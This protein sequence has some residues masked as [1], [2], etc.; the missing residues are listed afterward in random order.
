MGLG[1]LA[2]AAEIAWNQGINLYGVLDNRLYHGFEYTAK[3]MSG[4]EVP[5]KQYI[6]WYGKSVFGNTISTGQRTKYARHGNG[7]IGIIITEKGWECPIHVKSLKKDDRK[8]T[9]ISHSYHGLPSHALKNN[10]DGSRESPHRGYINTNLLK[11]RS[12]V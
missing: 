5:Y 1:F 6:T 11:A 4:E 3:Y 9:K 10:P 7:L 2:C 12:N 8:D